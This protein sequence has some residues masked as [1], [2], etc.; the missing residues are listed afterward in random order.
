MNSLI[1]ET[2]KYVVPANSFVSLT[3]IVWALF[4]GFAAGIAVIYYNRFILGKTVRR[5]LEEG[6]TSMESAKTLDELGLGKSALRTGS[7]KHH[8]T[9]RR[10]VEVANPEDAEVPVYSKRRAAFWN[11]LFPQKEKFSYDFDKMKL[12]I[13][14]EKKY[15]A[16]AKYEADRKR[17]PV[18]LLIV[19]AVVFGIAFAATAYAPKIASILDNAIS[20]VI[21]G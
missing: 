8:R 3:G 6:A 15:T 2:Y 17:S 20:S 14:E 11:F 4:G 7:L 13:P 16:E 19:L 9:L 10:F 18:S 21:N 1:S 5:L 12:Y